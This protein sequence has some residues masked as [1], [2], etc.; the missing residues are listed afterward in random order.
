MTKAIMLMLHI[1]SCFPLKSMQ[2][3]SLLEFELAKCKRCA[4]RRL[5]HGT[6]RNS[7]VSDAP[8]CKGRRLCVQSNTVSKLKTNASMF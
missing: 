5:F 6:Q 2:R 3:F 1:D 8:I 4:L 7:T